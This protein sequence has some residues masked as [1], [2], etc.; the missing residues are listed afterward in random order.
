[1][2]DGYGAPNLRDWFFFSLELETA[3][4]AGVSFVEAIRLVAVNSTRRAIRRSGEIVLQ[5]IQA[6]QGLS[7]ALGKAREIPVLIRNLLLVGVRGGDASEAL[8]QVVNHYSWLMEIRGRVLRAVTYPGMLVILG[9]AVMVGRD[10]TIASMT[11]AMPT[12]EALA[13]YTLK[14]CMPLLYGVVAAIIFAWVVYTPAIRPY[15]DRI[16]LTA[17]MVGRIVKAYGL[18]VFFRVLAVLVKAGL[19]VTDGWILAVQSV[20]NHKLAR[21]LDV[22]LR[23][24]QDGESLETAL[25]HG[26]VLDKAGRAMAAVGETSGDVPTML[27]KH[28]TYMT[29]ELRVK[30]YMMLAVISP[31]MIVGIAVGYFINVGALTVLAFLIV[32]LRRLI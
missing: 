21:D 12:E 22:G 2:P 8:R 11:G 5:Q 28:A 20:P 23:Y 9:T 4:T 3:L 15:F 7:R 31:F 13:F 18:A 30:T 17:P 19:P 6:G 26:Q 27:T 25:K 16:I 29:E 10:T 32:L 24:L 1:L 14:Y